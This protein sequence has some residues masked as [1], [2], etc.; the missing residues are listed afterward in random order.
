MAGEAEGR[1]QKQSGPRQNAQ[2][3]LIADPRR[4]FAL[5]SP[6][7]AYMAAG[8]AYWSRHRQEATRTRTSAAATVR[9]MMLVYHPIGEVPFYPSSGDG[10][11][12]CQRGPATPA[13]RKHRS[14]AWAISSR[15]S[16]ARGCPSPRALHAV[17]WSSQTTGIPSRSNSSSATFSANSRAAV[18][19]MPREYPNNFQQNL[20]SW[21]LNQLSGSAARPRAV[22]GDHAIELA[23]A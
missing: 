20:K 2:T 17:R 18:F 12:G 8:A 7:Y 13:R 3:A 1:I 9:L 23:G 21:F 5:M 14:A 6:D 15:A 19:C 11:V 16:A 10:A 4:H 22:I